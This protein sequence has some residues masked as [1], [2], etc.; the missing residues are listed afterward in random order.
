[1]HRQPTEEEEEMHRLHMVLVLVEVVSEA[2]VHLCMEAAE[3]FLQR[4]LGACLR[5]L[6]G[7]VEKAQEVDSHR[8]EEVEEVCRPGRQVECL[9][10]CLGEC[11]MGRTGGVEEFRMAVAGTCLLCRPTE[12]E[13]GE[14]PATGRRN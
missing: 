5:M 3:H 1:M 6:A 11:R 7:E 13:E 2:R 9:G 4:P 8:M 14:E 10:E 12:A